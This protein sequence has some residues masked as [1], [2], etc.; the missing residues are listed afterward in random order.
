MPTSVRQPSAMGWGIVGAS[1]IVR[2]YMA[3]ALRLRSSVEASTREE[4]QA[5]TELRSA[6]TIVSIFS[7]NATRARAF[8]DALRI[9]HADAQ[10]EQMLEHRDIQSVYVANHPRDHAQAVAA[11]LNAGKHVLCEAPLALDIA[12]AEDLI[13]KADLHGLALAI[14]APW[15]TDPAIRQL[16]KWIIDGEFGDLVGGRITN[17]GLLPITK[18]G[19]RLAPQ[20]GGVH[21]DRTQRD[22]DLLFF[23]TG[24]EV[25]E[26]YATSTIQILG[27]HSKFETPEDLVSTIILANAGPA[28]QLYDSFLVPHVPSS[29]EI[30]GSAGSAVATHWRDVGRPTSLQFHGHS[31]SQTI[32]ETLTSPAVAMVEGFILAV[33]TG[34]PLPAT[35]HDGLRAL[36]A[37]LAIQSALT[38]HRPIAIPRHTISS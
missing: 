24:Q 1:S 37:I 32:V 33:Q 4:R 13:F 9:P 29:V 30:Y 6:S 26:V 3:D 8:A 25:S 2:D 22:L 15:R 10:L 23:L 14:N 12:T 34:Q 27:S 17:A 31:R 38:K 7:P 36:R 28:F 19:W 20:G 35:G 5:P 18:Q 21:F 11:A 16:R